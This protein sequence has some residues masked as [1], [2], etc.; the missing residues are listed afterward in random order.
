VAAP[1]VREGGEDDALIEI[2]RRCRRREG[3]EQR[4]EPSHATQL[5]RA[6]GAADEV[7]TERGAGSGRQL[8]EQE[9]I[10]EAA[11]GGAVERL[12]RVVRRH[13]LYM[14]R[15]HRKVAGP[16]RAGQR[17]LG[18]RGFCASVR[19]ALVCRDRGSIPPL[20][21]PLVGPSSVSVAARARRGSRS[22]TYEFAP[23]CR[24]KTEPRTMKLYARSL[25][26]FPARNATSLDESSA[27]TFYVRA[28]EWF[29]VV[30][31]L[32]S[33]SRRGPRGARPAKGWAATDRGRR[34]SRGAALQRPGCLERPGR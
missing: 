5:S 27:L 17:G 8:I 34:G 2:G 3:A 7:A 21:S 19:H 22:V 24:A 12:A 20:Q 10:D 13:T 1:V 14:T 4:D 16:G 31:L 11:R 25:P 28:V 23:H 33:A 6:R 30:D 32:L 29:H 18:R 9:R 15:R 26:G